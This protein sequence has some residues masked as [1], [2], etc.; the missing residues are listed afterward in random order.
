MA[1][2]LTRSCWSYVCLKSPTIPSSPNNNHSNE[3]NYSLKKIENKYSDEDKSVEQQT[4][5]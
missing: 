2:M 4:V 3:D 5:T 1:K